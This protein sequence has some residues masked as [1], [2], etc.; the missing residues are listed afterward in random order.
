MVLYSIA[1]VQMQSFFTVFSG[2]RGSSFQSYYWLE[3]LVAR[4]IFAGGIFAR[5]I[6]DWMYY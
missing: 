5:V 3:L 4:V 6:I 2:A 1:L